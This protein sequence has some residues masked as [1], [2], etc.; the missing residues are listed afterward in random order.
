MAIGLVDPIVP[1][2][3][4][5]ANENYLRGFALLSQISERR[6]RIEQANKALEVR[7]YANELKH[8]TDMERIGSQAE[9]YR[10]M[11]EIGQKTNELKERKLGSTVDQAKQDMDRLIEMQGKIYAIPVKRGTTDWQKQFDD[12]KDEYSDVTGTPEAKRILSPLEQAH[13]TARNEAWKAFNNQVQS[14][15]IPPQYAPAIFGTPEMWQQGDD[16]S[17][18]SNPKMQFRVGQSPVIKIPKNR[19]DQLKR[20]YSDFYDIGSAVVPP[21]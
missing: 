17:D 11:Y 2:A 18:K 20:K 16:L 6:N 19:Y 15:G 3:D 21:V 12:I 13:K 7:M 4:N 5:T 14:L 8:D 1:K 10:Q 9:H